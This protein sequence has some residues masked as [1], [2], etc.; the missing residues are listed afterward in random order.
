MKRLT[1]GSNNL[2]IKY[3][4]LHG[5]SLSSI[6][7]HGR[8]NS[9]RNFS[10]FRSRYVDQLLTQIK[11]EYKTLPRDELLL[12]GRKTKIY[13]FIK[14]S[15]LDNDIILEKP[16]F[17]APNLKE[18]KQPTSSRSDRDIVA[19][20]YRVEKESM[21]SNQVL[22]E[23]LLFKKPLD[24]IFQRD[25]RDNSTREL[26]QIDLSDRLLNGGELKALQKDELLT[27]LQRERT[28]YLHSRELSP[29]LDSLQDFARVNHM[30]VLCNDSNLKYD[31][32]GKTIIKE[33]VIRNGDLLML[34]GQTNRVINYDEFN[35]S[36]ISSF[37]EDN[38][39]KNI[40]KLV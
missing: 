25:L 19:L 31:Y 13:G 9:T 38:L 18:M 40:S 12:D 8:H 6:I 35:C 33:S 29:L 32:D 37:S 16:Q 7:F 17:C 14:T 1:T 28:L 3:N 23:Y 11:D 27:I 2:I 21:F 22:V 24:F 30:K 4:I 36:L 34:M 26:I 20:H 10:L 39:H 5:S 15:S